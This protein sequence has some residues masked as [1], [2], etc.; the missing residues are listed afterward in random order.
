VAWL[1]NL[2]GSD[3]P[4]SPV[5]M[6]HAVVTA[7]TAVVFA[8]TAAVTDPVRRHLAEAGATVRPCLHSAACAFVFL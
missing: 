4:H 2:R 1:F 5:G 3:I 6:A 7:D 8:D